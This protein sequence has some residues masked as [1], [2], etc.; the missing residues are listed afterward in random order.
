MSP[1]ATTTARDWL[2]C[3]RPRPV[4]RVRLLCFPYATGNAT[5]Y[6]PWAAELPDDI[7]LVAVQ[8]PGRLDRINEPCIADMDTMADTIA[9]VLAPI[10]DRPIALFGHSMGGAIGF[11]VAHRIR[12]RHGVN[13]VRFFV[14]GRPPPEYHCTGTKHRESDDVLWGEMARLGGTSDDVLAHP[15]L[16]AA[17]MPT[18]RGDYQLIETYRPVATDPLA[19]PI[20]ALV[21]DA[22]PEVSV[23]QAMAWCRH[24]SA[25]FSL[26]VFPGNHFYLLGHRSAV[27]A[28][29]VRGLGCG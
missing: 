15:D 8:Y 29:V 12:D 18:L 5:F 1:L 26:E 13:P 22:D 4:A 19:T 27:I 16:R 17:L 2:R 24:T 14:S 9:R 20:T 21:G 3:Y 6:R 10:L 28:E 25:E 11:E 23:A 7:E